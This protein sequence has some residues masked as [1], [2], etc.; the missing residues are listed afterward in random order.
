MQATRNKGQRSRVAL[1]V[2]PEKCILF[3][4]S[5]RQYGPTKIA[6][7]DG[8]GPRPFCLSSHWAFFFDYVLWES[9]PGT[10]ISLGG[11]E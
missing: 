6:Q 3:M 8:E 2:T 1:P 9:F 10:R 7:H 4:L 5:S 11:D